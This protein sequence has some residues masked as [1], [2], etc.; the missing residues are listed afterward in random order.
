[1]KSAKV[2]FEIDGSSHLLQIGYDQGRDAWLLRVHGIRTIR[3]PN[4]TVLRETQK[5]RNIIADGIRA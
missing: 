5:T 2:A 1:M 3:I 4:L